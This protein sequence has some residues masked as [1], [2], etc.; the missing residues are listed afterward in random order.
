MLR[1]FLSVLLFVPILSL[2]VYTVLLNPA[3][4]PSR[5]SQD[6]VVLN[7]TTG[8]EIKA[9]V[10]G[11]H[12]TITLK[13]N[14]RETVTAYAIGLGNTFR[15]T[16]DFAYSEVQA[17]IA[18]G[19][20]FKKSYPLPTS[21]PGSGTTL[22]LL[23]VLL[24]NGGDDGNSLIAEKIRDERLGEK[25]QVLRTL[26]IL[27]KHKNLPRNLNALKGD[28]V[29]ALN[30]DESETLITLNELQLADPLSTRRNKKELSHDV[31]KGLQ[32]AREKM[33]RTVEALQEVPIESRERAFIESQSRS[34]KLF[35]KL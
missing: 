18:P 28:L 17:G 21:L 32:V 9:D 19:D 34:N 30:T 24:E 23:T 25:I 3:A 16:E 27:E 31:R 35:R 14:Y 15:I 5:A 26:R 1:P 13:N 4:E 11:D 6:P 22:Y 10:V 8:C 7:K 12:V 33:L 20:I 29:A 2:L